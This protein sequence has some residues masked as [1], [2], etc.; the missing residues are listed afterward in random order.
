VERIDSEESLLT[1][2]GLRAW[3]GGPPP[4]VATGAL[5]LLTHQPRLFRALSSRWPRRRL[6][7]L[8][9]DVRLLPGSGGRVLIAGGLGVGAP[10]TAVCVEELA[11]A[12]VHA[13]VSVDIAA[14]LVEGLETGDCVLPRY[15]RCGDGTSRHYTDAARAEA[16]A[17]LLDL[18]AAAFDAAGIAH[19]SADVYSTDAPFRETRS[20]VEAMRREGCALVD[21]E[22]AAL[23]AS[24]RALGVAAAAVLIVADRL[25]E[26]W[27][28][29]AGR[30][31]L[32]EALLAAGRAVAKSL[33]P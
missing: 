30:R 21:M 2:A 22:T 8:S 11:S 13:T 14:A 25:G 12:G 24:A 17:V 9:A 32:E 1:P 15:A 6:P 10:A 4:P 33:R 7:G 18:I 19:C 23:F 29:P 28:A 5:V 16:D 31:R 3:R 27:Q 26:A 20:A